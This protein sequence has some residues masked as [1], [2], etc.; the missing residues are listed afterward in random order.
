MAGGVGHRDAQS[1]AER[2]ELLVLE[3][4]E[5]GWRHGDGVV[6][7]RHRRV[8][9]ALAVRRTPAGETRVGEARTWGDQAAEHPAD[10]PENS[11]GRECGTTIAEGVGEI[12]EDFSIPSDGEVHGAGGVQEQEA[13]P[14]TKVNFKHFELGTWI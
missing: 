12:Q 9:A 14:S 1:G 6:D 3:L 8:G 2:Q 5:V 7:V 11:L 13:I 4:R 10:G